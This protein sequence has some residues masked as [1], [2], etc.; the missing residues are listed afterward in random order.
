MGQIAP[1]A[2]HEIEEVNC[3][4]VPLIEDALLV[5]LSAVAEVV[6]GVKAEKQEG[7]P[8]WFEG[9]MVWRHKR[10]PLISFEALGG[11]KRQGIAG[12][13]MALIMNTV[14]PEK[15]LRYYAI[16]AQDFS[17]LLRIAEDDP[18]HHVEGQSQWPYVLMQVELDG[19]IMQ[20]PDLEELEGYLTGSLHSFLKQL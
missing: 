13:S 6:Q 17:H 16:L 12:A 11:D 8:A 1:T 10:V 14:N 20:V 7:T 3:L 19:R 18:L 5:P 4:Y 2:D 9:W 15:G